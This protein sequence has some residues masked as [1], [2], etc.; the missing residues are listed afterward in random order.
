MN[1][2][3]LSEPVF[4]S[5]LTVFYNTSQEEGKKA[6]EK[7]VGGQITFNSEWD[8]A[9][10]GKERDGY[11]WIEEFDNTIEDI[12]LLSHEILHFTFHSLGNIG[13]DVSPESDEAYT[14]FFQYYQGRLLKKMLKLKT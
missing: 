1:K 10:Y 14:Y 12:G 5:N 2:I 4:N 7:C 11:I 9:F 13:L 6:I 3:Q 8:G